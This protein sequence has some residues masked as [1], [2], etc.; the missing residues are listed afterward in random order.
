MTKL[1]KPS[2]DKPEWGP[3]IKPEMQVVIE[4]LMS[5]DAPPLESL[6]AVEARKSPT[7]ADAV[8]AIIKENKIDVPLPKVNT[9]GKTIPV[10]GGIIPIRIYTPQKEKDSYPIILYI[11]GGGWVI[12]DID[13]Y[14]GSSSAMCELNEA[15]VVSVGYRLA[16]EFKFPV[17][18][19]DC[20]EAYQWIL[21]NISELQGD[22][23]RIALVGESAGG[24]LAANVSI[25]ARDKNLQ[26]PVAQ[27]LVYPVA[28]VDMDTP[29]YKKNANAKP[30]NKPMM[31]WF[32]KN[33]LSSTDLTKD[34]RIDL[35]TANLKGL[36][37]TIIITAEIDPLLSDGEIL[38]DK[39]I[40]QGV[41][42]T[43]EEYEGVTHEFF[44]MA[45]I[46]PEA[47]NAQKF[48]TKQLQ[49]YLTAELTF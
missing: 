2:G 16:P 31:E 33:T 6:T 30:L 38:R 22:V 28:Q 36:P 21:D 29:S 13:T 48:A 26:M 17:A 10:E 4:R 19:N 23:D 47:K 41:D 15:V 39:L 1:I 37:P 20:I 11:H 7:P 18:H 35:S 27:V 44:G 5:Y 32:V 42:V 43:Y 3:S 40:D 49:R 34:P 14:D 46:V 9:M 45:S 24:N 8:K 25:A 12:A